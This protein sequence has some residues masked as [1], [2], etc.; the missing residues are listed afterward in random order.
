LIEAM[1]A[2]VPIVATN[3]GGVRDVVCDGIDG[4]LIPSREV[5]ALAAALGR[6]ASR[7]GVCESRRR[8]V[9]HAFSVERLVRDTANLY[10][11]VLE[12]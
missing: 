8:A 1:A 9:R 4:E 7:A 5:E 12:N 11:Q 2:G 10:Q 6:V 3:V